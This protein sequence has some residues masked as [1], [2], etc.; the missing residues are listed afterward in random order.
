MGDEPFEWLRLAGLIVPHPRLDLIGRKGFAIVPAL[1]SVLTRTETRDC[2]ARVAR[3]AAWYEHNGHPFAAAQAYWRAGQTTRAEV[4]LATRGS[5]KT[6]NGCASDVGALVDGIEP[7]PSSPAVRRAYAE[8][9]HRSGDSH[10]ALRAYGPLAAAAD[11]A[12]WDAGL[13][14]RIAAVQHTQGALLEAL[15]TLGRVSPEPVPD[16]VEGTL[17]RAWV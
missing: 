9:L 8:A 10:A 1:V 2:G 14:H 15:G 7:R 11:V 6:A 12:G 4:L 16:D 5:E 13:A 17:W 3:A